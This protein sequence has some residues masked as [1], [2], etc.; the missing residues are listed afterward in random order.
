M[1][2]E[3][4]SERH[5]NC[6]AAHHRRDRGRGRRRSAHPAGSAPA[7]R[8]PAPRAGREPRHDRPVRPRT[9]GALGLRHGRDTRCRRR[10][11]RRGAERELAEARAFWAAQ[12]ARDASDAPSLL[13]LP[14]S[15]LFMPRESDFLTL[16]PWSRSPRRASTPTS[17]RVT[18]PNWPRP[19]AVTLAPGLHPGPV[20]R[21]ER[22]RAH[23]VLPGGAR[24]VPHG[25]GRRPPRPARHPRRLRLRRRYD[26][27]HDP[28]HRETAERLAAALRA[29]ETPVLLGGS[30]VSGAYA[31]T[32][33]CGEESIYILADRVIASCRSCRA[34]YRLHTPALFCASST[35]IN[36]S[37][38]SPR[39]SG[40]PP[41]HAPRR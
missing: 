14:D 10:G 19:V 23:G 16:E 30:G 33:A 21:R 1:N 40:R 8:G 5:A 13:G 7:G 41:N 34:L 17:T 32:F 26:P 29:G 3:Y 35:N 28:G 15:E 6:S 31:L 11:A 24:R 36:A 27:V 39:S 25:A 9:G 4:V 18:R 22:P 2:R 20:T 12:E 37:A 38:S